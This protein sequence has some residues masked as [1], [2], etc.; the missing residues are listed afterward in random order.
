MVQ[1]TSPP[2]WFRDV[3]DAYVIPVVMN[4]MMMNPNDVLVG[5]ANQQLRLNSFR[6]Q[7]PRATLEI[8]FIPVEVCEVVMN[9]MVGGG[10]PFELWATNVPK[11]VRLKT[12]QRGH[13]L[14]HLMTRLLLMKGLNT[15]YILTRNNELCSHSSL[16]IYWLIYCRL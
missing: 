11:Y 7:R 6:D 1:I 5:I 13:S 12:G 16:V 4:E 14:N 2:L 10:H 9:M 15:R 8:L 3:F